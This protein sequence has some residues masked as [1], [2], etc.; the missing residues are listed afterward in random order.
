MRQEASVIDDA[1]LDDSWVDRL[2]AQP[3]NRSARVRM[4]ETF[5]GPLRW[6]RRVFD[7]ITTTPGQILGMM[8]VLT[9]ALLAAGV[10]M[11]QTMASR[12]QSMDVLVNS[13]EPMSNSAHTLVTSL[14][15]AD[16]IATTAFVQTGISGETD[17]N[18]FMESVDA[19]VV[20]ANEVLE[21]TVESDSPDDEIQ[22][23]VLQIQ[24]D[25]PVYAGL[26]ERAR[27]NQRIGN[28]VS[29]AYMSSG[30]AVM[31]ERMLVNA[32]QVFDLTRGQVADEMDRLARPRWVPLS[33]LGAALLFLLLAQLWLWKIFRRR[34]NRGFVLATAMMVIAIIWASV[35]NWAVWQSGQRDFARAA[36]P[37]EALTSA[38]IDAQTTRTDE[39]FAL[40]RRQSVGETGTSFDSTYQS[41]SRALDATES[42]G[43]ATSGEK[44]AALIDSAR[45]DLEHW[46]N[47]HA[48][49]VR[50]LDEGDFDRA[51]D[52]IATPDTNAQA[53]STARPY[54][55]LDN[56]LASLI[57][58][59]RQDMR[60][61][62][63]A[64]LDATKAV[65]GAVLLLTMLSVLAIWL[66]IRRR[67]GEYL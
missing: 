14:S 7:F 34:L 31:R 37:W 8:L 2:E 42:A 17:M 26:I 30:S 61:F 6:V 35:A 43:P 56:S 63:I 33:G 38:R 45:T 52:V 1:P 54:T 41:V 57:G 18:R 49:L 66:G 58:Q 22:R 20:A 5:T 25:M 9:L 51:A 65:S 23:L 44:D 28:P 13:T 48:E 32:A 11:S 24:R 3:E 27:T 40:L 10:S 4:A 64:S 12:Q 50:A 47:A 36:L 53:P 19:A 55:E 15:Q 60:E 62:I 16:T 29:V 39:I 21:G 67:L 46:G 59:A